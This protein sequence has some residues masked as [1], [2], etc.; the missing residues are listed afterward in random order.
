MQRPPPVAGSRQQHAVIPTA[1]AL[2]FELQMAAAKDRER[3]ARIQSLEQT[4]GALQQVIHAQAQQVSMVAVNQQHM[5]RQQAQQNQQQQHLFRLN[6]S[7]MNAKQRK[8]AHRRAVKEAQRVAAAAAA[9]DKEEEQARE[10]ELA[11]ERVALDAYLQ[12]VETGASP[13]NIDAEDDQAPRERDE[14][15]RS[16]YRARRLATP[17]A[18]AVATAAAGASS[19]HILPFPASSS[20]AA[21]AAGDSS[22]SLR[23]RTKLS[24]QKRTHADTSTSIEVHA[25]VP[26]HLAASLAQMQGSARRLPPVPTHR[27]QQQDLSSTMAVMNAAAV[28]APAA[29]AAAAAAAPASR[30]KPRAAAAA[31]ASSELKSEAP[32][33]ED[34]EEASL[35]DAVARSTRSTRSKSRSRR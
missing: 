35:P 14:Y 2:A 31:A 11:D 9:H 20:A 12:K 24:G 22:S 26:A 16:Y 34:E 30:R 27:S 13:E 6:T 18:A 17:A 7:G 5:Q 1:A 15:V 21:A 8:A 29:A 25:G 23:V 3:S 4:V 19:N 28:P 32:M 10:L 33:E